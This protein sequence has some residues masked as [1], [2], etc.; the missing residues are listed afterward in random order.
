MEEKMEAQIDKIT[1]MN[2]T[3]HPSGNYSKSSKVHPCVGQDPTRANQTVPVN[4]GKQQ[5]T[6]GATRGLE[7]ELR[8]RNWAIRV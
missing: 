7:V 3:I 2:K 1:E 8:T 4:V 5:A 6:Q